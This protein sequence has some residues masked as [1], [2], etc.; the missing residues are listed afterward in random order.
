MLSS[1]H[2]KQ[3]HKRAPVGCVTGGLCDHVTAAASVGANFIL[4][5]TVLLSSEGKGKPGEGG[6]GGGG[7]Q[8]DK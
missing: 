2:A 4:S 3:K 6:G 7:P 1:A 5:T 8:E